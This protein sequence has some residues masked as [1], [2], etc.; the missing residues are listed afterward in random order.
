MADDN[1]TPPLTNGQHI[2]LELTKLAYRHD[3][4]PKDIVT[5]VEILEQYVAGEGEKLPSADRQGD[6]DAPI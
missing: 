5:K 1:F 3:R 4:D 6:S 2:R